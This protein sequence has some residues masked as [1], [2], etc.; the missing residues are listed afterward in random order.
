MEEWTKSLKNRTQKETGGNF[1]VFQP[2]C[3][4]LIPCGL[5]ARDVNAILLLT[6]LLQA[7]Q[8]RGCLCD[9]VTASGIMALCKGHTAQSTRLGTTG[10]R[11]SSLS[12]PW[13]IQ[14]SAHKGCAGD[15]VSEKGAPVTP[16]LLKQWCSKIYYEPFSC[17]G[18]VSELLC[19]SVCQFSSA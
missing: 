7:Y 14:N 3:G 9:A 5:Q 12:L 13:F 10:A 19:S 6:C 18:L 2:M 11:P 17:M 16:P 4:S 8:L 1:Q 15:V